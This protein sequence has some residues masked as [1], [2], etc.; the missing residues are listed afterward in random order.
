MNAFIAI[1]VRSATA[2]PS[3]LSKDVSSALTAIKPG[4][5]LT[6]RTLANQVDESVNQEQMLAALSSLFGIIA[7]FLAACGLFGVTSYSVAQRRA[8]IAVRIAVGARRVDVIRTV[9]S[10]VCVP[11]ALGLLGG[12]VLSTW[13]SRLATTL[14][15][16][17]TPGDPTTLVLATAGLASIALCAAWIPTRR[18]L[19]IDPV[20]V[21]R[22]S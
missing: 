11:V 3:A 2:P 9:L 8:E 19:K 13:L 16:G 7:L 4:L 18:A 6:A 15:F 17:V 12:I 10:R 22:A 5:S 1:G 14:L 20:Q 21:L